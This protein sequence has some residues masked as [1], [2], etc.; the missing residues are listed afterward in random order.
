MTEEEKIAFEV[1]KIA[2]DIE[3]EFKALGRI[4]S[5]RIAN[6][7]E[8]SKEFP[9][10]ATVTLSDGRTKKGEFYLNLSKKQGRQAIGVTFRVNIAINT[11]TPAEWEKETLESA[12]WVKHD[13]ETEFSV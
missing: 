8:W 2:L 3:Q 1:E 4:T 7:S 6:R 5:I 12:G 9:F 10:M 11:V 13:S